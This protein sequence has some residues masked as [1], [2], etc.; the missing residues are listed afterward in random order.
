MAELPRLS[1]QR[2]ALL[3]QATERYAGAFPGSPADEYLAGR[4]ISERTAASF[5]LG[6]CADPIEGHE[7]FAGRLA[8]PYL[9]PAGVVGMRF[10]K[11]V[12]T[13]DDDEKYSQEKAVRTGLYNVLDL[14]KSE[15]WIAVCEGELDTMV[16]SAV[17]GVPA[18]GIPGVDH[19]G[20]NG[21][22]WAR[23]LQDYDTVFICV[24]PDKAGRKIQADIARRV[25]NPIVIELPADVND[26]VIKHGA[27]WV[28]EKMGLD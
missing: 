12:L 27:P 25:E 11:L 2:R 26:T 3:A 22:T 16:M 28:L 10:R 24:D 13:E 7:R 14:H 23:L 18:I 15:P 8:I 20:V 6:Y 17:V 19:W 5:Q 1:A 21:S 9:T 4:A